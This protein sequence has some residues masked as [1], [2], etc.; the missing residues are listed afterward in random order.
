MSSGIRHLS[1]DVTL[2]RGDC[3]KVLPTLDVHVDA[4]ITDLPY[5]ITDCHWDEGLDLAAWWKCLRPL[6]TR[7]SLLVLFSAAR[8]TYQL[9]NSNPDW[10]R[11]DLVWEKDTAVG[12]LNAKRQPLRAHEQILVFAERISQTAYNP[13]MTPAVRRVG[14]V[15]QHRPTSLYGRQ[16]GGTV[17][18]DTGLR[19]PRSVIRAGERRHKGGHPTQKPQDLMEWIVRTYTNT[20]GLVLDTCMGHGSTGVACVATGRRFIGIERDRHWF[21]AACR[22]I[23]RN[24]ALSA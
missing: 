8:F 13:Q 20:G 4:V 21:E 5:G 9:Y 14:K 12:F 19:Y 10:Y 17:W 11:Y 3:L 6:L 2:C 7:S 15:V 18:K 22:R 16:R 23:G 1:S 24:L